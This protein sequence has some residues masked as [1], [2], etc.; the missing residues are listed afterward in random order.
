MR[1][2]PFACPVYHMCHT[3]SLKTVQLRLRLSSQPLV[4]SASRHISGSC[5]HLNPS[6]LLTSAIAFLGRHEKYIVYGAGPSVTTFTS[7][8]VPS[9]LLPRTGFP[10]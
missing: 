2:H 3:P 4:G 5:V 7:K 6:S 9:A 8:H 1:D 10:G